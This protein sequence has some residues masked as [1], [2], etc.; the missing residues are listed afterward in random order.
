MATKAVAKRKARS[1]VELPTY[2]KVVRKDNEE[3]GR[4]RAVR[5][6]HYQQCGGGRRVFRKPLGSM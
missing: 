1:A 2:S 3:G 4:E 6:E 5:H